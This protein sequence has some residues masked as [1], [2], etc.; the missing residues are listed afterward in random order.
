MKCEQCPAGLY[1]LFNNFNE[2]IVM[3]I[4]EESHKHENTNKK[5]KLSEEMKVEI[6]KLNY[7]ILRLN[8]RRFSKN[9]V[10]MAYIQKTKRNFHII[11]ISL[12]KINMALL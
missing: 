1:F 6:N 12:K 8:Q 9:F 4:T 2:E 7:L 11:C 5:N 3:F 10:K